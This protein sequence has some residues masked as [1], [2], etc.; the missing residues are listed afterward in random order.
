MDVVDKY[1]ATR[2]DRTGDL[3]ITNKKTATFL[4]LTRIRNG[5]HRLRNVASY[6]RHARMF[7]LLGGNGA[8]R[9]Y[10]G[11]GHKSGHSPLIALR[12]IGSHPQD[13][14]HHPAMTAGVARI[15]IGT[16]PKFWRYWA[17]NANSAYRLAVKTVGRQRAV[18]R[19]VFAVQGN[20]VYKG[21]MRRGA[22]SGS[23]Q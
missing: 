6:Q 7:R 15:G 19:S 18:L 16:C 2:R 10:A 20:L 8:Y 9:F 12:A 1:G 22:T 3:L 11:G 17:A 23:A 4:S 14:T 5:Y 13:A 21:S